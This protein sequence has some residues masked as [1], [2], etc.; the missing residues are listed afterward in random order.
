MLQG[1]DG[2]LGISGGE[3]GGEKERKKERKKERT[4]QKDRPRFGESCAKRSVKK[5][6]KF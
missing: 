5:K 6:D 3:K 2:K 1:L 4:M